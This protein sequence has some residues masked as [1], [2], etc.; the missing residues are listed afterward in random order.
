MDPISASIAGLYNASARFDRAS[1]RVVNSVSTG[2]D[3]KVAA[4][5]DQ[6]QAELAFEASATAYRTTARAQ[7]R[8]LDIMV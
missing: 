6:K 3:D 4:V 8:L 1:K 2:Q 7:K 5:V